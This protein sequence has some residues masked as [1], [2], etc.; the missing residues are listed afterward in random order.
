MKFDR[1][2]AVIFHFLLNISAYTSA[3]GSLPKHPSS[4]STKVKRHVGA[5]P[6]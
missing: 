5:D 1:W 6:Q 2:K 3:F 4:A